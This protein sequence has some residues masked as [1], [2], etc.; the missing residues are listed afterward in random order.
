MP[1]P[2][3]LSRRQW[4]LTNG[5]ALAGLALSTRFLNEEMRAQMTSE[6]QT[7]VVPVR[8]R[9][10]LN[11]NPLGPSALATEAM[12]RHLQAGRAAR[13]PY[14]EA[15]ELINLL[16]VREGVRP[17]QIVLGVGS[18]EIL[19][20][21]GL[22]IGLLKGEVVYATPGYLQMVRAVEAAGGRSVGVPVNA[23]LEHDL[24]AM[25]AK[26]GAPNSI[27]YIANPHNPTGTMVEHEAL[28]GFIREVAPRSLVFI[29]E[30]YLDFAADPVRRSVVDLVHA[31][32]NLVVARTF[33]KIYGLAG[34]RVG[35]GV[36]NARLA[37]KLRTYGLGTP[38]GPGIAAALASL[39][40]EAYVP[41]MR[42][43]VGAER[44]RLL[45]LLSRLGRKYA[46]PQ[47]NFVF[48]HTGRPHKEVFDRM[49]AESVSIARAF[50]PLLDWARISLGTPEENELARSALEK[51]FAA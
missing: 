27:V 31:Q 42:A 24:D 37:A 41:A 49:L 9:L 35:Y 43:R 40:D 2:T 12:I 48:F 39:R 51:V 3:P 34:L 36:M 14:A 7:A 33:S 15:G 6:R 47:T 5:T 46:E 29:D 28:R 30:A 1:T 38:N 19:E 10:S 23:R 45:A 25:A 20:T 17:E 4:L 8:A 26:A 21:V 13:Y 16:A 44:D 11:E 50:P 18:G 22:H 32:E